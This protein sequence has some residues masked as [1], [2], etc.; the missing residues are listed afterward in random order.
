VQHRREDRLSEGTNDIHI[1]WAAGLFEGEGSLAVTGQKRNGL[2]LQ[3]KM[4]DEDCV[5]MF[6]EICGGHIY[7]P[8]NT[9]ERPHFF[10]DGSKRKPNWSWSSAG[11]A[12][13]SWV[14]SKLF[15]YLHG[16]RRARAIE[17]GYVKKQYLDENPIWFDM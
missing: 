17:L 13:A 4:T 9:A 16:R 2:R 5:R 1:A 12:H 6:Q 10:A 15:P 7:G 11:T 14:L 8:Y 3:L